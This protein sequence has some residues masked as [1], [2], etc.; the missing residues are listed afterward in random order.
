MVT[1]DQIREE[2]LTPDDVLGREIVEPQETPKILPVWEEHPEERPGENVR[3]DDETLVWERDGY[4]AR[5]SNIEPT[6]W[7]AE[8]AVP[9]TYSGGWARPIDLK[10]RPHPEHGFVEDAAFEDYELE[11]VTLVLSENFQPVY[12]VNQ[13]IEF[14]I[15]S[16][17]MVEEFQEELDAKLDA[18]RE[19]E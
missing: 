3:L 8:I 13:Y 1:K 7:R 18:A 4:E 5:L 17:G 14:L 2:D 15:E 12:E 10:C 19:N 16:D 9:D 6:K 11:H